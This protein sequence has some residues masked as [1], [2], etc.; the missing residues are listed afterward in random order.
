MH[1]IVDIAIRRSQRNA[2]DMLISLRK[3]CKRLGSFFTDS[4]EVS[5]RLS[6][7]KVVSCE[8][9]KCDGVYKVF[10]NKGLVTFQ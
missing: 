7:T 6:A 9:T 5:M 8:L 1:E 3:D 10:D 4:L 2:L